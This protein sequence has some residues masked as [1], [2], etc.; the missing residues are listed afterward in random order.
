MRLV[1]SLFRNG[2][3]SCTSSRYHDCIPDDAVRLF[4][5]LQSS[6]SFQRGCGGRP[7][8]HHRRCERIIHLP[9]AAAAHRG[10]AT[11][12]P[13]H[14]HDGGKVGDAMIPNDGDGDSDGNDAMD[15]YAAAVIK[16]DHLGNTELRSRR[17]SIQQIINE[18]PGTH[19]RDFFS[20][21]LTSLG[22]DS[23]KRRAMMANHYSVKNTIHPWFILPRGSEIVVSW[24]SW[25]MHRISSRFYLYDAP[26]PLPPFL[27]ASYP[28]VR[29]SI[30][31]RWRSAACARSSQRIRRSYSTRTSQRSR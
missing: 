13:I 8:I 16:C 4:S 10:H 30:G 28:F 9:R 15:T 20:L 17:M 12:A 23:R 6:S 18:I 7:H 24:P 25:C 29:F 1:Q 5:I 11:I 31:K 19:P 14:G 3:A 22:D 27:M 21:S 2:A 26:R